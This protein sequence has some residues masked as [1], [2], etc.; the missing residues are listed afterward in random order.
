MSRK[1]KVDI[2]QSVLMPILGATAGAVAGKMADRF[3]PG[4]GMTPN[5]IKTA[6]GGAV[7]FAGAKTPALKFVGVGIA[8]QGVY[9][10]ASNFLPMLSGPEAQVSIGQTGAA[11]LMIEEIPDYPETV[12]PP[13]LEQE[14]EFTEV[15]GNAL[16]TVSGNAL[17]T[18]SGYDYSEDCE[19]Q[20]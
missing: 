10:I 14:E 12:L 1:K 11:P 7:A 2:V 18:V 19:Q 17:P 16:P 3:L 4:E 8:T 9:G 5:L 13:E 6:A 15:S 20:Y